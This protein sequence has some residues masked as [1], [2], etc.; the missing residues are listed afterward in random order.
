M[1]LRTKSLDARLGAA[2][3]LDFSDAQIQRT[4]LAHALLTF[5]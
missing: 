5:S 1:T 2:I 3:L 4:K